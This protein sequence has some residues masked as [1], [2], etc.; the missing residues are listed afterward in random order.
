VEQYILINTMKKQILL[1]CF[2]SPITC[3]PAANVFPPFSEGPFTVCIP[4]NMPGYVADPVFQVGSNVVYTLNGQI[5]TNAGSGHLQTTAEGFTGT[6]DK[7]T[8]WKTLTELLAVYQ[9]GAS[10]NSVKQLYTPSSQSFIDEIYT[11]ADAASRFYS[12]GRSIANMDVLLGFDVSNGFY[13]ITS[14]GSSGN[15]SDT[16]PYFLVQTNGQYLLAYYEGSGTN[17]SNIGTFLNTHSV[18][19]LV[20][21]N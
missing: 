12:F 4:T 1:I 11:N 18:T 21:P 13:V 7:S 16:M 10:S 17:I 3:L 5:F 6:T 8:P 2:L 15:P 19:N 9:Q 20:H 14:Y